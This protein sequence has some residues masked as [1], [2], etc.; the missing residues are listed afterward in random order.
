[1]QLLHI[2]QSMTSTQFNKANTVNLGNKIRSLR[3]KQKISQE[4]FSAKA[5]LHR[6]YISQLELGLRNPT[7]TTLNKIASALGV[8]AKDLLENG[9]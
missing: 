4:K 7:F 6:T 2:F 1:M 9:D 3:N 8:P 5:G